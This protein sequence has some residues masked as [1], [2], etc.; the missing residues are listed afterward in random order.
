MKRVQAVFAK[1]LVFC[2]FLQGA[3]EG[4][5]RRCVGVT[6]VMRQFLESPELAEKVNSEATADGSAVEKDGLD[7]AHLGRALFLQSQ[8]QDALL[9]IEAAALLMNDNLKGK[10]TMALFSPPAFY[11]FA[12]TLLNKSESQ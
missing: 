7:I 12:V 10:R 4:T 9:F 6:E 3:V 1:H 5:Y 8:K 2:G 11:S